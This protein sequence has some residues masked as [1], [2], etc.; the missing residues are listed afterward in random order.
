LERPTAAELKAASEEPVVRTIGPRGDVLRGPGVVITVPEGAVERDT[1]FSVRLRR[2]KP[3]GAWKSLTFLY[4][5]E[6]V[7]VVFEQPITIE[8][9]FKKAPA[10]ATPTIMVA[11]ID[12]TATFEPLETAVVDKVATAR[13]TQLGWAFVADRDRVATDSGAHDAAVHDEP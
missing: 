3:E 4:E 1:E 6:P 11:P 10:G 9:T 12:P 2:E 8:L 13:T 7:D 5:F